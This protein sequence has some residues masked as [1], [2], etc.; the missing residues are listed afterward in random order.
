MTGGEEE[1]S[2]SQVGTTAEIQAVR[3]LLREYIACAFTFDPDSKLAPTFQ[4]LE[5]EL[6]T[7]PGICTPPRAA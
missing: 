7:L 4:N 5:Q 6:A 2:V 1:L 3:E